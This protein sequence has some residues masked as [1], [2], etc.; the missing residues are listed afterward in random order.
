MQ[1]RQGGL[2]TSAVAR[3]LG[4][5]VADMRATSPPESTHTL[6]LDRLRTPDLTF[7]S[8]WDGDQ[9]GWGEGDQ[10]DGGSGEVVGCVALRELDP[11]HGELKSMRTAPA[12]RRRG[13]AVALLA[14][15]VE[16]AVAR[17][18]AALS[19]E[20]GSAE[21]FAPARAF[22]ARHGFLPCGP[23]GPYAADDFSV[24]MTRLL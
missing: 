14:T 23:F 15:V 5:H 4:D 18:Y 9:N 16:E 17:G 3:L 24:F 7:W 11:T 22:Y 2:D 21:F 19:L 1:I 13:V 6:D 12:Y 20:T 10:G 8:A